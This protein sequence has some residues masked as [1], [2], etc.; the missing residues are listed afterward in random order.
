VELGSLRACESQRYD[1]FSKVLV[2]GSGGGGVQQ[3]I[4]IAVMSAMCGAG[5]RPWQYLAHPLKL[6]GR[7][8]PLF[9]DDA[10]DLILKPAA[11]SRAR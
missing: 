9:S 8:D 7:S 2:V 1:G 6:A 5:V 10:A 11:D 3:R 4:R